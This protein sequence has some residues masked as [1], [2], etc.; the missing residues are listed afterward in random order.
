[1]IQRRPPTRT[2]RKRPHRPA[3]SM[4]AAPQPESASM[5]SP[6]RTGNRSERGFTLA[7][8]IV[9]LT[10]VMIFTAYTVPRQWSA[11]LQRDRD[12]QTLF[13][14]RQ[15]AIA[16]SAFQDKHKTWPVSMDQLKDAR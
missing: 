7:G 8:M 9:L 16:I 2:R 6:T 13:V 10:I 1:M 15:Y 4:Y 14:M 5:A 3:S 11:I 12:K